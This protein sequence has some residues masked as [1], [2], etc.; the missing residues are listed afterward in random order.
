MFGNLG[1]PH[2]FFDVSLPR[3][4]YITTASVVLGYFAYV[5]LQSALARW[6]S[7][8]PVSGASAETGFAP[9][10][11]ATANLLEFGAARRWWVLGPAASC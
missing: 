4:F 6:R 7:Q 11:L 3:R 1:R 9:I 2:H 10:R 5:G 8:W